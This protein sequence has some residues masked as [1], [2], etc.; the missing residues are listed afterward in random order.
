MIY[1]IATISLRPGK[2]AEFLEIF[3]EN[4]PNVLAEEGCLSYQPTVDV[5]SGVL[6]QDIVREHVITV[7][8]QWESLE[9]LRSHLVAPHMAAYSRAVKGMVEK[10]GLQVLEPVPGSELPAPREH[11][12][13]LS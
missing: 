13:S 7:V 11:G 5:G 12:A 8:E 9:R 6:I 1:V 2:R 10:V 3:N 4:I